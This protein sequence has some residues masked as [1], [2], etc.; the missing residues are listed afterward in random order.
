M[1]ISPVYNFVEEGLKY[2]GLWWRM[3]KQPTLKVK[4]IFLKGTVSFD[5]KGPYVSE[6]IGNQRYRIYVTSS[7]ASYVPIAPP[8]PGI[9][10]EMAITGSPFRIVNTTGFTEAKGVVSIRINGRLHGMASRI[11]YD[12]KSVLLLTYHQFQQLAGVENVTLEHYGRVLP[13][14]FD[15]KPLL[16]SPIDSFDTCL[17]E[18]PPRYWTVL[19]VREL[20]TANPVTHGGVHLFGFDAQ[21]N[22]VN[23]MGCISPDERLFHLKHSASTRNAFSGTPLLNAKG[24]VVALHCG[25]EA[26]AQSN[27]AVQLFWNLIGRE[28]DIEFGRHWRYDRDLN[29]YDRD[30]YA[31]VTGK[32]K[33]YH[34]HDKVFSIDTI[35]VP[36]TDS[37]AEEMQMIDDIVH[38]ELSRLKKTRGKVI[39]RESSPLLSQPTPSGSESP[40]KF[41]P[42][43]SKSL[44][45]PLPPIPHAIDKSCGSSVSEPV[46]AASE[47]PRE[48]LNSRGREKSLSPNSAQQ[49]TTS[50]AQ[51]VKE[52][53]L[54]STSNTQE[55]AASKGNRRRRKKARTLVKQLPA[56]GVVRQTGFDP[57]AE[58]AKNCAPS[59]CILTDSVPPYGLAVCLR[60]KPLK[61]YNRITHSRLFNAY[62]RTHSPEENALLRFCA[63][64]WSK[65]YGM[66]SK[67]I[68]PPA[69]LLEFTAQPIRL[70]SE[71]T[72]NL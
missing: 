67:E 57:R 59:E 36:H 38:E 71:P 37:W 19:G 3:R 11:G 69:V 4:D 70:Y 62:L 52:I 29:D 66:K 7:L 24:Q 49:A 72:M 41:T 21:S 50:G 27:L 48:T 10:R 23:S 33:I 61:A 22:F 1:V 5:E 51:K 12:G 45:K 56:D 17:Y 28:S 26:I 18:L 44:T 2:C 16:Y 6:F 30:F 68:P 35:E 32:A 39:K 64:C 65:S 14:V 46:K 42:P 40:K 63:L 53:K 34:S 47:R 43:R 13:V 60:G 31:V 54:E 9:E 20:S 15:S 55:S 25:S 8:V 58:P